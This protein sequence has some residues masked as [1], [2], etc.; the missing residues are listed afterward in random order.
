MVVD[1]GSGDVSVY[2]KEDIEALVN[3]TVASV[4]DMEVQ[5]LRILFLLNN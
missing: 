2:D 4:S 1:D 3:E 5:R